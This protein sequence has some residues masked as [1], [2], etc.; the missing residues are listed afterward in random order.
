MDDSTIIAATLR[1]LVVAAAGNPDAS[2]ARPSASVR[3]AATCL[4]SMPRAR[5]TTWRRL[6]AIV[7]LHLAVCLGTTVGARAADGVIGT[8]AAHTDT[9]SDASASASAS[10]T[11]THGA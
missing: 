10:A 5:V 9:I 4:R 6:L 7:C 1:T 8:Q 2:I 11:L 3:D